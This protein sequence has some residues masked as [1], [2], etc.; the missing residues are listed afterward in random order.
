MSTVSWFRWLKLATLTCLVPCTAIA[1]ALGQSEKKVLH[2]SL[3][4]NISSRSTSRSVVPLFSAASLT[5]PIQ[6]LRLRPRR[7]S[8]D[9]L[10]SIL[11]IGGVLPVG[12]LLTCPNHL[13]WVSSMY[14]ARCLSRPTLLW[15]FPSSVC[16]PFLVT[17]LSRCAHES[18][19]RCPNPTP[20]RCCSDCRPI[21]HPH[22][23]IGRSIIVL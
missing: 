21:T 5:F 18:H 1:V 14:I 11:A 3:S 12:I 22:V 7:P 9:L 16:R 10:V 15:C 2:F 19:L 8:F 6:R 20:D 13:S 23:I 17:S 4:I